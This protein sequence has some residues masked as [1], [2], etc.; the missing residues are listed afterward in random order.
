MGRV[1]LVC[2]CFFYTV[3]LLLLRKKRNTPPGSSLVSLPQTESFEMRGNTR[4]AFQCHFQCS[5]YVLPLEPLRG[6]ETV[7]WQQTGVLIFLW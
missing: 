3:L 6:D 2:E 4:D 7:F 1:Y 5:V